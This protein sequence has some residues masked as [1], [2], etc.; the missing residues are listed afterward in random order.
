M[1]MTRD[2]TIKAEE[3]SPISGQWYTHGILLD[4]TECS[5]LIDTGASKSYSI[6]ILLHAM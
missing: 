5:I 6:K 3:R 4:N 1:D 2:M